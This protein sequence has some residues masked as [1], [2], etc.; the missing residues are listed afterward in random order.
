MNAI[1]ELKFSL[2]FHKNLMTINYLI[3]LIKIDKKLNPKFIKAIAHQKTFSANTKIYH[4]QSKSS[5]NNHKS[6]E[7]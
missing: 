2:S 1:N 6:E 4:Q 7:R 5:K 3:F